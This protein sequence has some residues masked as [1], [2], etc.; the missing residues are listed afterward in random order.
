M[1]WCE[2]TEDAAFAQRT[3][4]LQE[5]PGVDTISVVLVETRQNPETLRQHKTRQTACTTVCKLHLR[6]I[7]KSKL[8]ELKLGFSRVDNISKIGR[9]ILLVF[10][11]EQLD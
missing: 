3:G 10:W 7:S 1:L 6:V 8:Q 11:L 4:V 9:E 2:L 5:Q